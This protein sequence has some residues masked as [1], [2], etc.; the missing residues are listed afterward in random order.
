MTRLVLRHAIVALCALASVMLVA[1]RATAAYDYI[2]INNPF[3][4]KIPIA[5]PVF[6]TQAGGDDA[7][8]LAVE[9]ADLL[10][11]SLEFT[12]Y[13]KILDRESFLADPE[14]PKISENEIPFTNW[15]GIGADMLVT[16]GVSHGLE[17]LEFELRLF[18]TYK[19][20][21]LLGK[22][23]RGRVED[24][25]RIIRRFCSEVIFLLTGQ[26]G[27]FESRIALVSNGT[28]NKEI[29]ICEFDGH[30]PQ[31]FTRNGAINLTPAWSSDGKWLAYTSYARGNP[32]LYIRNIRD[33][34]GVVVSKKGLNIAPAWV[35][36]AFELAATLSYEGDPEIYLLTGKGEIIKRLT[37]NW[38]NDV[39]PSFSPDGK[40]M[41]FV[42][43]RS[44]SPQIYVQEIDSGRIT[45]LTF[46]GSY[47]TQPAWSS[48]GD[49]IAYTART[50]DRHDI[51]L[52]GLDGRGP[53]Q[54]TR[55]AG[56]NES[57]SWAPDGSLIVFSSTR[58]GVPKIYVMTAFGTD[59]RRLL[60]LPGGQ[61][62][63][64]W[65]PAVVD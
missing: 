48:R 65:S 19:Q 17:S 63:P 51:C 64:K 49:R 61:T 23:Y 12:G 18:D 45:R 21:M 50:T 54:L 38:G 30:D 43:S 16:G 20:K 37:H 15:T 57:P 35:P 1:S 26:R 3:L 41:A 28:G 55:D 31:P 39:S 11:R 25:R 62:A 29:Y 36:G 7:R 44:G 33:R 53:V 40:K 5:V 32:D 42:S 59:Q 8:S 4:R 27:I 52:I 10:A 60:D 24:R 22:R 46:E 34:Q 13:F 9:S 14:N 56:N 2:N 58:E 6:K 47:N